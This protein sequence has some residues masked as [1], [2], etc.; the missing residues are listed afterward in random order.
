MRCATA[1]TFIVNF[2]ARSLKRG[3]RFLLMKRPDAPELAG[4][5]PSKKYDSD[6]FASMLRVFYGVAP[7]L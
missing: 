5:A 7:R 3:V 1:I 4:A 2:Y 6:D